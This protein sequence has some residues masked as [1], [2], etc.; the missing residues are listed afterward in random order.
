L[1]SSDSVIH[2]YSQSQTWLS[3]DVPILKGISAHPK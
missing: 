2:S 3:G 1:L